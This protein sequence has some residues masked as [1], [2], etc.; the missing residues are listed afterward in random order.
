M[1]NNDLKHFS[2]LTKECYIKWTKISLFV[3]PSFVT[4]NKTESHAQSV[5]KECYIKRYRNNTRSVYVSHL[6]TKECYIWCI[7]LLFKRTDMTSFVGFTHFWCNI[8]F[9]KSDTSKEPESQIFVHISHFDVKLLQE[10]IQRKPICFNFTA[11]NKRMIHQKISTS[12][13]FRIHFILTKEWWNRALC[14]ILLQKNATWNDTNITG[15]LF[16]F[17][18][19]DATSYD[20][21]VKRMYIKC[22]PKVTLFTFH[23]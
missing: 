8:H 18:L 21:F 10:N 14:F 5:T 17:H 22:K 12:H 4:S 23:L 13:L 9:V 3:S 15:L 2:G 7:I 11:L 6:L 19:F 16:T 20:S 1:W